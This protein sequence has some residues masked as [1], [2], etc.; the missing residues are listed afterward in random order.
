MP[1]F[2]SEKSGAFRRMSSGGCGMLMAIDYKRRK[3]VDRFRSG[4]PIG[5]SI[6]G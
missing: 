6:R 3:A 4:P 5:H 2:D 1:V